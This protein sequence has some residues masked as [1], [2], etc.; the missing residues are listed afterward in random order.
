[1]SVSAASIPVRTST[2]KALRNS[3]FRL[4]FVG[5]LASASG[6]WVQNVAQGFL[7]F[8]ITHS[9]LWLG[10][11]ACMAG[12]PLL[13]FSPFAG[14]IVERVPR[15]R[16]MLITQ[17]IQ[18][19]LAFIL[20][21]LTFAEQ[22]EVWHIASLAL[23]LGL[24][25]AFDFP[26]RQTFVVE[27]VGRDELHSGIAL[28]SILN[29]GSRILGPATAGI[30]LV[31][32]GPAWCFFLNG[33]SFLAVIGSLVWLK[34][35]YAIQQTSQT[36]P[37]RQLKEGLSFVRHDQHIV[38][39]LLLVGKAGFFSVP[40][41]T[42]FPAF[43]SVVLDSPKE[44]YAALSVGQGLG[45]VVA[46]LSVSRMSDYWGRGR[47]IVGFVVLTALATLLLSF[48]TLIPVAAFVASWC[49]FTLV[50]QVVSLNTQI[51]SNVPNEFR[52]R[53]LGLYTLAFFGLA[54]FGA[55]LLGFIAD[56]IGTDHAVAVYALLDGGIGAVILMRWSSVLSHH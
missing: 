39:L 16:L 20:A 13:L 24:T 17:V 40:I 27:L 56:L 45:S 19:G 51:Q 42:L 30:A 5:Q 11:V 1:M 33:L 3:N 29:S 23:V 18:M 14:V 2:L 44:G 52:G 7:V 36:A 4:Y 10:I 46:G 12:I 31:Q 55:L 49:G 41:V 21:A 48:Q 28:V 34:V 50:G 9:E 47:V 38:A 53:V 35:P 22:V 54:P 37:L 25:N 6:T 26:A 43:A 8:Q 15:R 32:L